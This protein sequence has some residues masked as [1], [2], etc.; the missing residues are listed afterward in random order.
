[1]GKQEESRRKRVKCNA[2]RNLNRVQEYKKIMK[3]K[4]ES[5]FGLL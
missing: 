5:K 4:S 1:M 3:H 2:E